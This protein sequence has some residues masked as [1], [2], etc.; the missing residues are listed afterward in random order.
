LKLN[1]TYNKSNN[2]YR[3]VWLKELEPQINQPWEKDVYEFLLDWFLDTDSF[4]IKTSG[5]TG[6]PKTQVFNRKSLIKSAQITLNW[7][8][9]TQSE[10][11]LMCLPVHFVAGKMMLVRAMVGRMN[12]V[13]TEPT[14]SP[15]ESLNTK[16]DF[17]AFT[18]HQIQNI[19]SKT[20]EKLSFIKKIILGGSPVDSNLEGKLALCD[21]QVFETFGM[22]ETLTHI[23]TRKINGSDKS[24]NFKVVDGFSINVDTEGKLIISADHIPDSPLHTTD[25]IEIIN[26]RTFKWIARSNDVINSGGIKLFPSAIEKKIRKVFSERKFYIAKRNDRELG[27]IAILC[28]EGDE[29]E[30]SSI[31]ELDSKLNS[32]L[33]KFERPKRIEFVKEFSRN[34]NGKII[35]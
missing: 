4:K 28:I 19:L 13:V 18:P 9:L 33:E 24:S 29:F 22:S 34:K 26:N 23:A 11:L 21:A 12:L 16:I 6:T 7:F 35:K 31:K 27:E 25:I 10:T 5:T 20:P 30:D 3:E 15:L 8:N 17:A 14:S 32:V 1:F 2:W